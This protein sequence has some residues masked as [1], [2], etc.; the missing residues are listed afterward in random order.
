MKPGAAKSN[1]NTIRDRTY[2]GPGASVACLV[3]GTVLNGNHHERLRQHEFLNSERPVP[4]DISEVWQV[5][6]GTFKYPGAA[7]I[8]HKRA[9]VTGLPRAS[10][11][12]VLATSAGLEPADFSIRN[13]GTA[14]SAWQLE[15]GGSPAPGG[16]TGR[17]PQQ[18]ADLMPRT[19]VCVDIIQHTGPEYRV[20]TPTRTSRWGF[21]IKS[22]K[23]MAGE[24]FPGHVAPRFIFSMAQSENLL[25]FVLGVHRAPLAL[26]ALRAVDGTWTILDESEIRRQGFTQSARRFAAINQ[27]L[28]A[29]GQG[30]TLQERVDERGKLSKQVFGPDGF[31]IL[32]GAGGKN[33]CAACVPLTEA[34]GLVVDQTLYWRVV[35][36]APEAWFQVGMLNSVALTTATLP[37]NPKGDFSE[38]HL[39]T[40]PYRL[41]PAYDPGNDDHN[42]IAELAEKIAALADTRCTTDSYLSD[43][44]K[45]LPARRRKLRA[46]LEKSPLL[47]QL[48]ALAEAA[49]GVAATPAESADDGAEG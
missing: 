25:P 12:G 26:P 23:E 48:E 21:T 27:K 17:L 43:P 19:A 9:A 3:P 5:A 24:R 7:F 16:G 45:A 39:H 4:F 40:L 18:G 46:M 2:L 13:I 28:K 34:K 22:A 47:S 30:K 10:F 1:S 33:I 49:L 42:E 15:K 44:A 38:R 29:V 20:D 41:M 36:D 14:R 11:T 37:F 31:L 35:K 8:G 6:P 32:A